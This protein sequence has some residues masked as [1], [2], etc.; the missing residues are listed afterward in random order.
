[1]A[2]RVHLPELRRSLISA[3]A[4]TVAALVAPMARAQAVAADAFVKQLSSEVVDA[5]KGDKA[6]QSGDVA[7][8]P[9]AL[10]RTNIGF[11]RISAIEAQPT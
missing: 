11:V 2:Q 9:A 1:M 10:T 6:I 5:V 7:R 4:F 8:I 3:L